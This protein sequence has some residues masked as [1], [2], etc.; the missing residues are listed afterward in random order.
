[1]HDGEDFEDLVYDPAVDPDLE[2]VVIVGQNVQEEQELEIEDLSGA[3][4]LYNLKLK[5]KK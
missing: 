2:D 3:F 1:M 5:Y 4:Q